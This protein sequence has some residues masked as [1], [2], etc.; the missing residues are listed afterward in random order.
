M[1]GARLKFKDHTSPDWGWLQMK[2]GRAGDDYNDLMEARNA[3]DS[4]TVSAHNI[5]WSQVFD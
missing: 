5:A 4:L 2:L 3:V 1:E